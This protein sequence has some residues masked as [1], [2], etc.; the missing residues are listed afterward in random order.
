VC[1]QIA[2]FGYRVIVPD[3][4]SRIEPGIELGLRPDDRARGAAIAAR[5]TP[6]DLVADIG[7]A[8]AYLVSDR[9][10][11]LGLGWGAGAAWH[12]TAALPHL[13]AG[14][15]F[16]GTGIADARQAKP[17][18]P[19]QLHFGE[20]DRFIPM[21][22]V[23]AIRHAQ[24]AVAIEVYPNAAHLFACDESESFSMDAAETARDNMLAFLTEYV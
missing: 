16:Y 1:R 19:V 21:A 15:G 6:A 10:G 12:A 5:L 2:A 14:I 20:F 9:V 3:L 8:A 18:C 7:A 13:R 17:L 23:E 22:D 24:P 11:V 4:F